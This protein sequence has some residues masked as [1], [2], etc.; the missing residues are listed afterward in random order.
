M[1]GQPPMRYLD[2]RRLRVLTLVALVALIVVAT[3]FLVLRNGEGD[4]SS[5]SSEGLAI[6][7][8]VF[9]FQAEF[10]YY[11]V[12]GLDGNLSSCPYTERLRSRLTQAKAT[13]CRCQ[14]PSRTRVLSADMSD[15]GG[16]I[17]AT[18]F[19]GRTT[20]ALKVVREHGQLLVDDETC[21]GGAANTSIYETIAPC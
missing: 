16:M 9:P 7:E 8:Q 5:N 13:L 17:Y 2:S 21:R 20:F 15:S 14:N 19:D 10:G 1:L 6:G 3:A 12:C 18:L 11:A 4:K